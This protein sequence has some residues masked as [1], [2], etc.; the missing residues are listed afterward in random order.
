MQFVPTLHV[1]GYQPAETPFSTIVLVG[2]TSK[3]LNSAKEYIP[4]G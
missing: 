1:C 3:T 4:I 2:K